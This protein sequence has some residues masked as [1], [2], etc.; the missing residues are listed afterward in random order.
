MIL[1]MIEILMRRRYD[2]FVSNSHE[3][4]VELLL[5]VIIQAYMLQ[6]IVIFT[7]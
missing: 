5:H 2:F 6:H 7:R 3:T 4:N 1:V